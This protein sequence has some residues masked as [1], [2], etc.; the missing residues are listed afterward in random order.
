MYIQFIP[1]FVEFSIDARHED[2]KVIEQVVEV[3]KKYAEGN[4]RLYYRL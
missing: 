4:S 1:D 2:P 3:I